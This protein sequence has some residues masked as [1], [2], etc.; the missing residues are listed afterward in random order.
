M[1]DILKKAFENFNNVFRCG[2]D[3]INYVIVLGSSLVILNPAGG[4][5]A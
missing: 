3:N 1:K 5:N 4:L 2:G